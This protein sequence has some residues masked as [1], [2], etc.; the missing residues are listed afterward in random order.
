M[1]HNLLGMLHLVI[2]IL[3]Y[4]IFIVFYFKNSK[5][6]PEFLEIIPFLEDYS[7]IVEKLVSFCMTIKN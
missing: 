2:F 7:F 4:N 1:I 6:H 5:T 3:N